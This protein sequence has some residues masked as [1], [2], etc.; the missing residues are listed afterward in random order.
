MS[1]TNKKSTYEKNAI[2]LFVNSFPYQ[3]NLYFYKNLFILYIYHVIAFINFCYTIWVFYY[4][5]ATLKPI[6]LLYTRD[7]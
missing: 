5:Q 7:I 4:N 3:N 1:N 6:S 2:I